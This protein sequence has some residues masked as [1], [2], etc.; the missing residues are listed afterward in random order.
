MLTPVL[1]P[2]ALAAA[3]CG[4]VALVAGALLAGDD[5]AQRTKFVF[6]AAFASKV[7]DSI[8]DPILRVRS[9]SETFC[10]Q[11]NGATDVGAAALIA[12]VSDAFQLDWTLVEVADLADCP[13]GETVFYV[14]QGA[15]PDQAELLDLVET[16][17]GSRPPNPDAIFPE[18]AR[19]LSVS[20]PGP[21]NREFVFASSSADMPDEVA[22]SILSEELLQ[23][24][25]RASDVPS[26]EIVSLLGEDLRNKDYAQWFHHN[27]IGFCS[28]DI[29]LLELLLGPS[30]AGLHKMDQMRTYLASN[31][32][33]LLKAAETRGRGLTSYRDHRCWVWD[34]P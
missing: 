26:T 2:L 24:I 30:T 28:V 11:D 10:I 31:F 9:G 3:L 21:G 4:A 7:T 32:D 14:L 34:T 15:R 13:A 23:S 19:G 8:R 17:V 29:I 20:L 1:K 33:D 25:L 5:L 22:R 16:I 6:D 18:W 12:D 27:P